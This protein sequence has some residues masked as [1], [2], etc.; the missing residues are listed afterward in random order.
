MDNRSR[1][2]PHQEKTGSG[3]LHPIAAAAE[4]LWNEYR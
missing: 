4:E 3:R 2:A 1:F